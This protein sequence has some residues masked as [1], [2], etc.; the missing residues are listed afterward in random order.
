V[1]NQSDPRN[2]FIID[3]PFEIDVKD[4]LNIISSLGKHKS[5][6]EDNLPSEAYIYAKNDIAP[7]LTEIFNL[8]LKLQVAPSQWNHALV[9]LI[10]KRKGDPSEIKNYR[11]ISLTIVA[12]RIYEKIIDLRL[13][14]FKAKLHDLQGGFRKGRSTAQQI[15]Y[16]AELMKLRK[17]KL[18]NV[19]L[20]FRAAYD[21][22]DRR[23]LWTVLYHKFQMPI[24]LIRVVRSIFDYNSSLLLVG[25]KTS[26]GIFNHRGVPQG[27]SLSP[28]MFNFFINSLIESIEAEN[29]LDGIE[30][31]C[32]FFADDGNLHSIN[33]SHMQNLLNVCSKWSNTFGMEF[34]AEKCYVVANDE[35]ELKMN[36]VILPQI[37]ETI[38]LGIPFKANGPNW[39]G[40]AMNICKKAKSAVMS[41]MIIGFN[42]DSWDASAKVD[43]YKLFVRPLMEYGMQISSYKKEMLEMFDRVQM[44]ALRIANGVPWN[45]SKLALKRLMCLESME[46]RQ[47]ILNAKYLCRMESNNDL[48]IPAFKLFKR[49]KVDSKSL[50][51][52]W[53]HFN[54]IYI[55]LNSIN[56]VKKRHAEIKVIRYE[57]V[58]LDKGGNTNV[59]SAIFVDRNLKHSNLL[60]WKG[61][62]D[63]T[64]KKELIRWRL[65]RIAS[66]QT[67]G[68][69]QGELS[70]KHALICSGAEDYLEREFANIEIPH[71][72]TLL[73]A[74]LNHYLLEDDDELWIFIFS[75][76]RRKQIGL[77]NYVYVLNETYLSNNLNRI[78]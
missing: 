1:L 33:K 65:G 30:S 70:R 25:S 8:M 73:D 29:H 67:C 68:N 61:T 15:H 77:I 20:D 31:N 69:C 42:K 45:T 14:E 63:S 5:P 58:V 75:R 46:C 59:S 3:S 64:F 10:Y 7:I 66:H 26:T 55:R 56:D 54:P 44:M 72:N 43:V 24:S 4:V 37:E 18:I 2:S 19:F 16:L 49:V 22:V 27:S 51:Y 28:T 39:I 32:I 48:S 41:L 78:V 53:S 71:S 40:H 60:K 62:E 50:A 9:C 13:D 35:M 57:N 74:I 47:Q 12:K 21:T 76:I 34:A 11:P 36:N 23:I 17:K 38:Y 6:G 52:E